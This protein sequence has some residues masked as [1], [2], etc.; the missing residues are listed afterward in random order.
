MKSVSFFPLLQEKIHKFINLTFGRSDLKA[1]MPLK[2]EIFNNT[3][4]TGGLHQSHLMHKHEI[5]LATG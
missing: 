4:S 5:G 2:L 1:L 3:E